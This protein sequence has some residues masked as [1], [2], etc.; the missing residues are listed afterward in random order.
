MSFLRTYHEKAIAVYGLG[1]A[2]LAVVTALMKAG[3]DV[4]VWDDNEKIRERLSRSGFV[5]TQPDDWPWD[6]LMALI[7]GAVERAGFTLTHP[8]LERAKENDVPVYSDAELFAHE[9]NQLPEESRPCVIGI[10]GTHGKSVTASMI[11]HVLS[12]AGVQVYCAGDA[13]KALFALPPPAVDSVYVLELSTR[14]LAF[15]SSLRC[16]AGV[17]LNMLTSDKRFFR[18]TD[19][20]VK[21]IMRVFYN[22]QKTDALII[23]A[24]D[25]VGQKICTAITSSISQKTFCSEN[26]TPISG[27]AALGLGVFSLQGLAYDARSDKTVSLVDIRKLTS[28]RGTHFQLNVAAAIATALHFGLSTPLIEKALHRWGG[29]TGRMKITGDIGNITFCNDHKA[30]SLRAAKAALMAGRELFWIGG[31]ADKVNNYNLLNEAEFSVTRAFLYGDAAPKIQDA[32]MA[33]FESEIT[34]SPEEAVLSAIHAAEERVRLVPGSRPMVLLSPG[35]PG[36]SQFVV[37]RF[38]DQTVQRLLQEKAA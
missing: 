5:F 26:I 18:S 13:G 15:T 16:Q 33:F 25:M 29:L 3:A 17:M 34:G 12:S 9:I 22:Q 10:T 4:F 32:T 27:E 8:V 36:F 23:G 2:G 7:P 30:S 35:C 37:G 6:E 11:K 21:T 20:A 14:T 1:S 24:D 38:F 19:R 28:I 31:G